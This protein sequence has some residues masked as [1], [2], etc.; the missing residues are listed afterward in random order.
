[1][2]RKKVAVIQPQSEKTVEEAFAQFIQTKRVLNSSPETI[3]Y[4]HYVFKYFAEFF[5][6]G[7]RCDEVSQDT[8]LEY[9]DYLM[10]EKPDIAPKT[11]QTYIK[12]LRAIFYYFMENEWVAEFKI[13]LPKAEDTIKEV[14]TDYE[15]KQLIKKP[16][17]KTCTFADLRNWAMVCYFLSTGNRL[18][19]VANIRI[20]DV[21]LEDNEIF[22]RKT[23]Q[24][25]QYI[26]PISSG[27]K[28]VL[29]EYL[30]YRK[31]SPED[32]LFVSVYGEQFTKDTMGEVLRHYNWSR[33]VE[34]T[35]IH[36][37]RHTFAK[38]WIMNGGD[39]FRLQKV[40]GHSTL[41]MVKQYVNLYSADL[42]R[43][44]DQFS[45]FD[46]ANA[47]LQPEHKQSMKMRK[48]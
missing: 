22:V 21:R 29:Q 39:I 28:P 37:F 46:R 34:K 20:G 32:F 35:G 43:D 42:K 13:T 4:Y 1:M 8:I 6:V 31:G 2:V 9:L 25:K 27:L 41:D 36:L 47:S 12:G 24:K 40:L 26:L 19:T 11:V 30:K 7:R 23:K 48:S 14:Y 3:K 45:L 17:L 38:N 18:S 15:V 44:Y 5:D 10:E 33:G 16:D